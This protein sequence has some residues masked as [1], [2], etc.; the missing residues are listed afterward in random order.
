MRNE[1]SLS[2]QPAKLP[3][4]TL[5][6]I[7]HVDADASYHISRRMMEQGGDIVA[8]RTLDGVGEMQLESNRSYT[9][10]KGTLLLVP[11]AHIL[12]YGVK[13][14]AW[15]FY[16]FEFE[17]ADLQHLPLSQVLELAVA[18]GEE[19]E[20]ARCFDSFKVEKGRLAILSQALFQYILADWL[21]AMGGQGRQLSGDELIPLL[22]LGVRENLS[23]AELAQRACMCERTFRI[24]VRRHTGKSP[25]EYMLHDAL[26]TALV[27]LRTTSLSV[28]E[29]AENTG[30]HNSFYFSRVFKN[31][32]GIQPS[33]ARGL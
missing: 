9:L 24:L 31:R 32:F 18:H 16:W 1:L 5:R 27:L 23:V 6:A 33:K 11:K 4:L 3:A 25:K 28:A 12:S 10:P 13:Y 7:W 26:D 15:H 22:S 30:F 8:L 2:P 21:A 29:V 20:L 14:D 17:I 19:S